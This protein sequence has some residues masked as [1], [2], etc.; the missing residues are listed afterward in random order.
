MAGPQWSD[1][2]VLTDKELRRRKKER[3][4]IEEIEKESRNKHATRNKLILIFVIF[5]ILVGAGITAFTITSKK[6]EEERILQL[7]QLRI[8]KPSGGLSFKDTTNI[9]TTDGRN[10]LKKNEGIRTSDDGRID[11]EFE[12]NRG[13]TLPPK[14]EIIITEITPLK[15]M[16][17]INIALELNKGSFLC[18]LQKSNGYL[19]IKAAFSSIK[20]NPGVATN[21]KIELKLLN[22]KPCVR[23]STKLGELNVK[24][25]DEPAIILPRRKAINIFSDGKIDGPHDILPGNEVWR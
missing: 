13:A 22:G 23:I 17:S 20:V 9:W 7:S 25:K 19:K 5:S 3:E 12:E 21:F 16:E 14:S 4:K 11:I 8:T 2:K 15:D 24:Y 1:M 10:Y 18:D 6:N